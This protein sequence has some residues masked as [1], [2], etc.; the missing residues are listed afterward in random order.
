[1]RTRLW[2]FKFDLH[3]CIKPNQSNLPENHHHL[4]GQ[5]IRSHRDAFVNV[6]P[7]FSSIVVAVASGSTGA[8][9]T[10]RSSIAFSVQ[11]IAN[12]WTTRK[13]NFFL[14]TTHVFISR[15][16]IDN[17]NNNKHIISTNKQ[18]FNFVG[19]VFFFIS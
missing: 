18:S 6:K 4:H 11:D 19:L 8:V 12:E 17:L 7:T 15:I 14:L 5:N 3:L 2:T 13:T 1:M 10:F 9:K 16:I